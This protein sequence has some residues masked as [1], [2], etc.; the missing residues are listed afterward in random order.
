MFIDQ[1]SVAESGHCT[2]KQRIV[3]QES[4]SIESALVLIP[5]MI[6]VLSVLQLALGV[7]NRDIAVN[8]VQSAVNQSS[9]F[10]A[11]N[12][13]PIA[14]MNAFGL[15]SPSA[16]PLTGGG[17]LYMGERRSH[18]PSLTPLLPQGDNFVVSGMAIG[19]GQ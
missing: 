2:L 18:A 13:S 5:L 15:S 12:S 16:L 9:K 7:L 11:D 1:V 6:L 8:H 17:R 4:G 10:S 19:E 14:N 3:M